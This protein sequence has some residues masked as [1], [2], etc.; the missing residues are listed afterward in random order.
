VRRA[1]DLDRRLEEWARTLPAEWRSE[2]AKVVTEE[3]REP[4][5]AFFWS[6]PVYVYG[7]LNIANVMNEYRISRLLCQSIVLACVGAL[8]TATAQAEHLQR[9]YTEA[10]YIAQQMVNEV[11]STVPFMLGFNLGNRLDGESDASER[12]MRPSP[13]APRFENPPADLRSAFPAL[14]STGAYFAGPPLFI[15]K[16]FSCI[17]PKQRQWLLGR[18]IHIGREFGL[19]EAGGE[20]RGKTPAAAAPAPSPPSPAKPSMPQ[21]NVMTEMNGRQVI[22]V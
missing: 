7:D 9:S 16:A 6:G 18:L 4:L 5:S 2:V 12:G 3:P 21:Y 20:G 8:P 11:C 10:V 15:A 14:Q 13:D 19:T 1:Q 17:R 22:A